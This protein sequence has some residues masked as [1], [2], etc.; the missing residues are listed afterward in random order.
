MPVGYA[1]DDTE[2]LILNDDGKK[3]VANQVGEIAVK[4]RYLSP[5]Y[6]RRPDLTAAK[7]F[8]DPDSK[9]NRIYHSGDMGRIHPD[10]CLEHLGR[11]DFQVKIRGFKVE[12]GEVEAALLGLPG[13]KEVAVVARDD[14]SGNLRL[15]AYIVVSKH[16]APNTSEMRNFL[17]ERLP[18]Y[19]IPSSFLIL[20]ALPMTSTDKVNRQGLPAPPPTRPDLDTPFA[21]P[22]TPVEE[23]VTGIWE[24]VLALD[25]VGIHDDFFALGGHSL[26]A[27]QVISRVIQMFQVELPVE[28]LFNSPT[29]ADMAVVITQ[30]RARKAGK[31][32]L[33]RMLSEVERFSEEEASR[34]L[35]D[36][37]K[38]EGR[39]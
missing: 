28:S 11:K 4:G 27:A 19:M 26:R 1:V 39:K 33:A 12:V 25:R 32:E 10:G 13:I 36:E 3:A 22:R 7:F 8:A 16:P 9:E 6:W 35:G 21:P 18:D 31:S 14:A 17:K 15:V 29:V 30:N 38:P 23:S 5:G 34:L 24:E 37:T 20:D 2:I